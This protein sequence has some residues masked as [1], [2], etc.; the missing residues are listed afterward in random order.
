MNLSQLKYVVEV[1]KTGSITK[2]AQNL[3]MGQPNL[4]KAI[5]EL[6]REIGISIFKRTAK[7]VEVTPRGDEFL[8][9]A[10]TIL[11]Q[12]NELESLY[13]QEK[14]GA[15]HLRICAPRA[16]YVSAAFCAFMRSIAHAEQFEVS[17]QETNSIGAVNA[18]SN[19]EFDLA[20]IRYQT[21]YESYFLSF[22]QGMK[23]KVEPVSNYKMAL[24]LSKDH[25]LA[26]YADIP[27]HM[28]APYPEIMHGDFQ[29]PA[30][31]FGE[32][33]HEAKL[34]T[35]VKRIYVYERGSQFELL[36]QVKGSYMWVS[37]MPKETLEQNGLIVRPCPVGAANYKDMIV[38]PK[39]HV[40][41][42]LEKRFVRQLKESFSLAVGE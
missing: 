3:L 2:A 7:G 26:E 17:F 41:N 16:S 19:G 32:I 36:R 6:E 15:V 14:D 27:Y 40:L 38:Y 4:S 30:M 11:S 13:H 10:N 8:T 1:E 24:L 21:L 9:Y 39:T 25:P 22:I 37:P 18:V 12:V 34:K 28:L 31:S 20:V 5:R 42:N 33:S 29:V 23:L 35:A